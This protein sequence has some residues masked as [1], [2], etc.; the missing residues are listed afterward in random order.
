MKKYDYAK[1]EELL[2]PVMDMMM[3]EFPN[4][5]KLIIDRNFS[6]ITFEHK[7]LTIPRKEIKCSILKG[8]GETT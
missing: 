4:D 6:T 2:Q 8:E 3:E 7:Y 5:C 1:L